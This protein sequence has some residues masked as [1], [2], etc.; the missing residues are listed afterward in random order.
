[1][2]MRKL[3]FSKD[4]W[5]DFYSLTKKKKRIRNIS[6]DSTFKILYTFPQLWHTPAISDLE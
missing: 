3:R 4:E 2:H 1:M 5:I 6:F